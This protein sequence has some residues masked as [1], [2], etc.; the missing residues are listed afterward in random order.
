[1]NDWNK[2]R[3]KWRELNPPNHQG[4]WICGIC[5]QW[6]NESEMEVD[7]IKPRGGTTRHLRSDHSNLQP[8]HRRCNQLKGSKRNFDYYG[9]M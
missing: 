2:T 8:A 1:M 9:D 3:R 4:Y 7:H 6:V 5:G